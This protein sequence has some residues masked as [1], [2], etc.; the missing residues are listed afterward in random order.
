MR[1][2]LERLSQFGG[3]FSEPLNSKAKD[4]CPAE[5]SDPC[6]KARPASLLPDLASTLMSGVEPTVLVPPLELLGVVR[7]RPW[8]VRFRS[9]EVGA[10]TV[11]GSADGVVGILDRG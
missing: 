8:E 4:P 7:G 9:L 5:S 2:D 1:D 11:C 10:E 6:T 3:V